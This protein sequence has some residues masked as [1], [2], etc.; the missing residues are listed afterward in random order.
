M[1]FIE[2]R[3]EGRVDGGRFIKC[4]CII[5]G[6]IIIVNNVHSKLDQSGVLDLFSALWIQYRALVSTL[7]IWK[8][9]MYKQVWG[10]AQCISLIP[11]RSLSSD[12]PMY[13]FLS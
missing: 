9:D 13:P 2:G 6:I 4:S 11:L 3:R 5:Y 12:K 8:L 1:Y 7:S 10:G